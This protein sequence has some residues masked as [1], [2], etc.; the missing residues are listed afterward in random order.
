[1]KAALESYR[2]GDLWRV[3]VHLPDASAQ[4]VAT[5]ISALRAYQPQEGTVTLRGDT[6]TWT[7][8]ALLRQMQ[9]I[10]ADA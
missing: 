7:N 4:E 1:M 3:T 6:L 2:E 10:A 5:L 9:E 8:E